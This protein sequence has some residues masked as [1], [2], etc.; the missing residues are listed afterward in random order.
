MH[1]QTK[2]SLYFVYKEFKI[3]NTLP[4]YS[5]FDIKCTTCNPSIY[6]MDHPDLLEGP[7]WGLNDQNYL[8]L[9]N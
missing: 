1:S 5:N 4:S 2:S 7:W 9:D 3:E 6:K 8:V